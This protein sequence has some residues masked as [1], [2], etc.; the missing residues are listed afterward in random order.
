M[1]RFLA[2]AALLMLLIG[3]VGN[4]VGGA[5]EVGYEVRESNVRLA[6]ATAQAT[7]AEIVPASEYEAPGE[8]RHR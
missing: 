6:V 4:T 7:G 3:P 1:I 8:E 2:I 5:I